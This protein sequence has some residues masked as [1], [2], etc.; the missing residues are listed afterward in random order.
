[1]SSTPE[2]LGQL[3][4][5]TNTKIRK[6]REI[7]EGTYLRVIA[8][9]IVEE[10]TFKVP[11]KPVKYTYTGYTK[12]TTPAKP[13]AILPPLEPADE[14]APTYTEFLRSLD[15]QVM[16]NTM[17]GERWKMYEDLLADISGEDDLHLAMTFSEYVR[18]YDPLEL[19]DLTDAEI[20]A[21]YDLYVQEFYDE[22]FDQY[23]GDDR[24]T[25]EQDMWADYERYVRDDDAPSDL[26]PIVRRS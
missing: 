14:F 9:E 17:P 26:A 19:A 6:V 11:E 22:I 5:W 13:V 4:T 7:P 21:D 12:T 10:A 3:S 1:M 20:R 2:T 25:T 8:G 16:L 24:A 23:T 18:T 15:T